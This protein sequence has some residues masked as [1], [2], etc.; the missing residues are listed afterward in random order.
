LSV[1]F[2]PV[3]WSH[4]LQL[5]NVFVVQINVKYRYTKALSCDHRKIMK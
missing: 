4:C 1:N 5:V 3:L 2:E